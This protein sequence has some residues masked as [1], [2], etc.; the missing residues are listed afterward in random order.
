MSSIIFD[1]PWV[2]LSVPIGNADAKAIVR[3]SFL[4]FRY[5]DLKHIRSDPNINP[6]PNETSG[7]KNKQVFQQCG[8]LL[9]K[10]IHPRSIVLNHNLTLF[11]LFRCHLGNKGLQAQFGIWVA[12]HC[13]KSIPKISPY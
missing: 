8:A 1:K 3:L 10:R 12:T 11:N 6:L 5:P 7:L 13:R 9:T 2:P 4:S